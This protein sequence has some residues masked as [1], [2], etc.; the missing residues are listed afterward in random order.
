MNKKGIIIIL[1]LII[2]LTGCDNKKCIK[3]HKEDKLCPQPLCIPNGKGIRC[4]SIVRPCK[5]NVCDEYE[6]DNNE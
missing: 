4:Y 6:G 2:L 3:S 1:V 5:V